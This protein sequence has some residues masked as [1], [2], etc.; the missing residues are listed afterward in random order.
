MFHANAIHT[1]KHIDKPKRGLH[2]Y[3]G[4]IEIAQRKKGS[5]EMARE[6]TE[7]T[8]NISFK[9]TKE[10]SRM[11]KGHAAAE[12]RSLARQIIFEMDKAVQSNKGTETSVD[13][14]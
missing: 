13:E 14:L 10:Q 5:K 7:R 2:V 4:V 12:G 1:Q 6:K 8:I 9:I 3:L 11:W